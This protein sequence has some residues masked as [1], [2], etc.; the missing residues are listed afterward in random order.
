M[1]SSEGNADAFSMRAGAEMKRKTNFNEIGFDVSYSKASANGVE[2]QHNALFNAGY[3]QFLGESRWTVF[4][5]V[6][7]EYDEFRAFDLRFWLNAGIGYQI[8][9]SDPITW[10]G[11]FGAGASREFGGPMD[12]WVPEAVF[13]TDYD[14]QIRAGQKL[15]ATVDY[16]PAWENFADYR[17]VAMVS[18]ELL[19][20]EEHDVS[21]KISV[22]DRYDST[23]NGR[24]PNDINYAVLLLW[25][26]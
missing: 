7:L 19:L 25:T 9:K 23:P 4:D 10:K 17:V 21:L 12:E 5:K 1:N 14:H 18:W 22:N 6:G 11:R 13:G 2:S 16:F 3:E 20:S 24:R 15:S 8:I 26:L